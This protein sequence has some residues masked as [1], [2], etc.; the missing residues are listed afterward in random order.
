M[1]QHNDNDVEILSRADSF[2]NYLSSATLHLALPLKRDDFEE[3]FELIN[4]RMAIIVFAET[5]ETTL[6]KEILISS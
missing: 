3:V 2:H 4:Y 1:N 5:G 6:M